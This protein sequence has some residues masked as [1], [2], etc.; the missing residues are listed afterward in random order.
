MYWTYF[1]LVKDHKYNA[2]GKDRANFIVNKSLTFSRNTGSYLTD[3]L[4]L[5]SIVHFDSLY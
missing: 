5:Y 3:F 2:L 1:S 4:S